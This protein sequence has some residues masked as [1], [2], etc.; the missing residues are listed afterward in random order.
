[1]HWWCHHRWHSGSF[2][3]SVNVNPQHLHNNSGGWNWR[4]CTFALLLLCVNSASLLPT[5]ARAGSVQNNTKMFCWKTIS[6][7]K[8]HE[9]RTLKD[10]GQHYRKQRGQR[11]IWFPQ[12]E[13]AEMAE[14]T[15]GFGESGKHLCVCMWA[16]MCAREKGRDTQYL[17]GGFDSNVMKYS[18]ILNQDLLL[19][20]AEVLRSGVRLV[21]MGINFL[22]LHKGYN[23]EF[24]VLHLPKC[25]LKKNLR[26]LSFLWFISTLQMKKAFQDSSKREE[27]C[28]NGLQPFLCFR[29]WKKEPELSLD[30]SDHLIFFKFLWRKTIKLR[31]SPVMKQQRFSDSCHE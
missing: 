23:Y 26:N 27:C 2:L 24:S 12:R 1:M 25:P 30:W 29:T 9:V 3:S 11:G 19:F 14:V 13:T 16:R 20:Q 22:L 4:K 17:L 15:S 31:G 7:Q 18:C 21:Q 5:T 8:C 10:R 6:I 28:L